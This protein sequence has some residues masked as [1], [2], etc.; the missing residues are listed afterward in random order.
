[1]K[2][3]FKALELMDIMDLATEIWLIL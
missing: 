2:H 1:L 3:K